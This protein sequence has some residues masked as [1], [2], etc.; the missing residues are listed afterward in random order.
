[1]ST[2]VLTGVD[3]AKRPLCAVRVVATGEMMVSEPKTTRKQTEKCGS[4]VYMIIEVDLDVWGVA[5]VVDVVVDV[6]RRVARTRP[7]R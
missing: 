3:E 5:E 1:M 2:N 4:S 6:G 7:F